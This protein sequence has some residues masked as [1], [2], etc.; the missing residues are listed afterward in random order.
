MTTKREI[1]S[2]GSDEYAFGRRTDLK[3]GN[4]RISPTVRSKNGVAK[5]QATHG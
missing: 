2:G 3:L 5:E 4:C 1:R